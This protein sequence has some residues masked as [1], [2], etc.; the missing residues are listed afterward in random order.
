MNTDHLKKLAIA[1]TPGPWM[2]LLGDRLVYDR[3]NDGCRG[4]SIVGV[5]YRHYSAKE[6]ANLDY[7]AAAN[8]TAILELI[9]QRDELLAA[10]KRIKA[11][12]MH[13][14]LCGQSAGLLHA[15]I[16]A[17]GDAEEVIAKMEG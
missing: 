4:N 17:E 10:L 6:A 13:Q 3:L 16:Q 15:A 5:D 14:R 9:Q 11:N 7:V 2:H 1:A 12:L 8:P